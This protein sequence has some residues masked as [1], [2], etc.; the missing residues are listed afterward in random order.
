MFRFANTEYLWY[1]FVLPV[2]IFLLVYMRMRRRRRAELFASS[3]LSSQLMP[4]VSVGRFWWRGVLLGMGLLFLVLGLARPQFGLKQATQRRSGIELMVVLDVSR[5]MLAED[6]RP[7][8]LER[9]K[10]EISQLVRNL[11]DDRIGLILFAGRAYVQLPITSD[12]ASS[13]MYISQVS[14]D[15]V[16]EPGTQL[17]E[18][19]DLAMKSFSPQTDVGRAIV[20]ISDGENH[21]G[22]PL[23]RAEE[24]ANLGVRIYTVGIG[25]P[26]GAPIPDAQGGMKKDRDG[27]VVISKLDEVTLSQIAGKTGGIYMRAATVQ[28]GLKPIMDDLDRLQRAELEQ[29]V[30]SSYDEQYQLAFGLSF[31]FFVISFLVFERKHTWFNIDKLFRE[32]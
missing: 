7:N 31:F 14:C 23:Q 32:K 1:L 29:V 18:A 22:N 17:G 28:S 11:K 3:V 5:S 10:L 26:E 2:Y 6:V 4:M 19:L 30:Y 15:M 21:E 8:R 27:N 24:A 25:S 13:L 12:Y 16:S 9:A 20:V